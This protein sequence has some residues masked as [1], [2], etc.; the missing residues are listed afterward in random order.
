[1]TE[2]GLERCSEEKSTLNDIIEIAGL[3]KRF[4]SVQAVDD[5]SFTVER[6]SLF[7]FL[8]LNGAG[9]ST[10]INILCSILQKDAGSVLIDGCDLEREADKIK[11]KLGIV[12]QN[13]VLDERLTVR[14]NLTVRASYYGLRGEALRARLEELNELLDLKEILNRPFGK[15]SGGQK[16]RAD[17]AR[18]LLNR[19]SLLFLDEPTTGLDPKTRQNV[20]EIILGL[21]QS[22][23]MTVFLTTHYMEEANRADHVVIMDGGRIA[24]SDTPNNLKNLYSGDY[25]KLYLPQSPETAGALE[26]SGRAFT[27]EGECYR[28]RVESSRDALSFLNAYPALAGDFEVVKGDMDDVFLSVT[29]KK[30]EGGD[31]Q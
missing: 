25:V 6:G 23:G 9:K 27:Y 17:I 3:S 16:R 4:G 11:P 20:W 22:A 14:E 29:G 2:P 21:R 12:F 1:M 19:P 30:L 31:V 15:L 24:A 18:G 5:I 28:V 26:S 13:S 8:G 10:T 7:A